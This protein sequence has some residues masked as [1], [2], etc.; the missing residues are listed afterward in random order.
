MKKLKIPLFFN[1]KEKI[2]HS[3]LNKFQNKP[4]KNINNSKKKKNE[5]KKLYKIKDI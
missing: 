3:K 1:L 5:K 4:E 2:N